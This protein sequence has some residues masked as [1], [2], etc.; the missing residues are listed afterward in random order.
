M[1][2]GWCLSC[3]AEKCIH[4]RRALL[5]GMKSPAQLHGLYGTNL[6]VLQGM[7]SSAKLQVSS[8]GDILVTIKDCYEAGK[9]LL[10]SRHPP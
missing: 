6:G 1:K 5:C 4:P 9:A 7:Q 3:A 2:P 10:S 8:M